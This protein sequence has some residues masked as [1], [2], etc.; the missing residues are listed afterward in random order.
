MKKDHEM[1]DE[2][3]FMIHKLDT[4][5]KYS[6]SRSNKNQI[7]S[8]FAAN[9]SQ[10]LSAKGSHMERSQI[11]KFFNKSNTILPNCKSNSIHEMS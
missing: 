2:G 1:F 11:S 8:P 4:M 10:N 7:Q 9:Q 5:L 3:R 6:S